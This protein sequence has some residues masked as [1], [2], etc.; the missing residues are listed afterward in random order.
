MGTPFITLVEP[1]RIGDYRPNL[2]LS[3][4]PDSV[5]KAFLDA[6]AVRHQVFVDEQKVPVE[7]EFDDDDYRSCHWVVYAS[8]NRT[9]EPEVRDPDT[10]QIIYPRRSETS[11]VPVGTVRLVPYPH[12]PHPVSGGVYVNG[13]LVS[14]ISDDAHNVAATTATAAAADAIPRR[15][16][17]AMPFTVERATELHD[18]VEPYVKLGRLAVV[19]E[20]R[21]YKLSRLL[22]RTALEWART[23]PTYFQ[24]SVAAV[25]LE[26]LGVEKLGSVP[27]WL[28][29]VC[30]HAQKDVVRAWE[31]F[32]FRV[33]SG[34][35]T[36]MEEGITHVGMF[37]R[38]D[39]NASDE[40]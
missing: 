11:T 9:V 16:S 35:G 8:V 17:L 12:P 3:E 4:Q 19:R 20:F 26:P 32:G 23:H 29:L 6:M 18:G 10:D 7:N 34:M 25:G 27:K 37:L 39:L 24:P 36:W 38:L 31:K 30:C 33:D 14:S 22:V 13:Q 15:S 5:P 40:K 28:G 2:P 1:G 21:G